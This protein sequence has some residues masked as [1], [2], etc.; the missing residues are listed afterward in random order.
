MNGR[1]YHI[2]I[3]IFHTEEKKKKKR[4]KIGWGLYWYPTFM[5]H[6]L[7]HIEAGSLLYYETTSGQ[8][9]LAGVEP[10]L[11]V[12]KKCNF[13]LLKFSLGYSEIYKLWWFSSA[14]D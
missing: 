8:C 9:G 3:N 5:E 1:Y 11:A 14:T 2:N 10:P 12:I 7:K 6:L 13:S 4:R